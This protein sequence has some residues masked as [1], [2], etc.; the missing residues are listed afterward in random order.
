MT[1]V[2]YDTKYLQLKSTPSPSG[3]EWVYAHRPNATDVVIIVPLIIDNNEEK[4]LFIRE[5]RPPMYAELRGKYNIGLAAGLV[6]DERQGETILDAIKAEL[7]EETGFIA[8]EIEIVAKNVSSSAGC[9]SEVVTIAIARINNPILHQEPV[10]DGGII[11]DRILVNK[12]DIPQFLK[13]EQD[14]GNTIAAHTLAGL[15]YIK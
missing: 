2:L 9:T 1:K 3:N 14:E 8:D 11:V 15:Y 5:Q 10:N 12:K 13:K 6:G 4:V 7:L